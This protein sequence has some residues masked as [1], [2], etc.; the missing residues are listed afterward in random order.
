MLLVDDILLAPIKSLLWIFKEVYNAAQQEQVSAAEQITEALRQ[1]YMALETGQITEEQFDQQEKILLD[2]LDRLQ[3]VDV[4]SSYAEDEAE[5]EEAD[6][7][8]EADPGEEAEPSGDVLGAAEV[9]SGDDPED[10]G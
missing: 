10:N 5:T 4:P 8:A 7:D 3:G 2:R 1:L 6:P 9:S